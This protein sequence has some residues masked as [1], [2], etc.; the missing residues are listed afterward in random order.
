MKFRTVGVLTLQ[1]SNNYGAM[2][3]LY[4]L[5]KYLRNKGHEVFV[6]DYEMT[7]DNTGILD[8][9][10]RPVS[11]IQKLIYRR[12][13]LKKIIFKKKLNEYEADRAKSYASIFSEFKA[14]FMNITKEKYNYQ[15]LVANCPKADVYI[16]GSDQVWAADFLFTSP[17]FLLGFVPKNIKRVSY[18]ASFGKNKLE[19]YLKNVFVEYIQKFDAISVRE[20][21][22]VDIVNSLAN[23][24][25]KHV[26]DP[27]LLLKKDDYEEIID[28]SLVPNFPY[29]FVYKLHQEKELNDWFDDCANIFRT[30]EDL[31][32][33]AVSTNSRSM[34]DDTWNEL[35]PTPGQLLGL[36][37]KS[38]LTITNS[39][40]GTVFSIILQAKF[41]TFARDVYNDRQN[42]RM[43]EMLTNLGLGNFYCPPF[44]A[45]EVI[46]N[47]LKEMPEYS[48]IH[49]CLDSMRASSAS[50]IEQSLL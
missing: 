44:L 5:C 49:E 28:Y 14:K 15:K 25:A 31:P 42:V 20:K 43:E 17:A 40:H 4:A 6:V 22:G 10:Q 36:I 50:F 39:F 38:A 37:E 41:L 9:V 12:D 11:F 16:S 13:L 47:K 32:V 27:T 33:L 29:V 21:S 30:R 46:F 45:C 7:R 35:R 3:Q 2:Y 19:P 34:F 48:N 24:D 8:Y 18:A 23:M 26:V 1:N